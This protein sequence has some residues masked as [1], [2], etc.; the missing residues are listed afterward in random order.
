MKCAYRFSGCV[1]FDGVRIAVSSHDVSTSLSLDYFERSGYCHCSVFRGLRRRSL[2]DCFVRSLDRQPPW[3]FSSEDTILSQL[4]SVS[5][6]ILSQTA[7]RLA[8]VGVGRSTKKKFICAVC[9]HYLR[10]R[11]TLLAKSSDE[12]ASEFSSVR[13]P[14]QCDPRYLLLL[15]AFMENVYGTEIAAALRRPPTPVY[16]YESSS[17]C[18]V[19]WIGHSTDELVRRLRT[20]RLAALSESILRSPLLSR[21]VLHRRSHAH[22][23]NSLVS[24]M[25]DRVAC[26]QNVGADVLCDI[27]LAYSPYST[28]RFSQT[29]E[30]ITR[31][32]TFEYGS[33]VV[34]AL[35]HEPLS[36]S[37]R[38]RQ[39][40]RE[41]KMSALT[42]V[43]TDAVDRLN[44][45]PEIVPSST[46][47]ACQAAY[48]EGTIW[49]ADPVCAV[50]AQ[51]MEDCQK[52]DVTEVNSSELH[53]E[54]LR[55]TDAYIIRKCILQGLSSRFTFGSPIL[56]GLMLEKVGV[57]AVAQDSATLN[58]CGSC[59]AALRK[60]DRVPRLALKN[61]LY[62][63]DLPVQFQDLTWI[64]EKICAIYCVT[65][66]VTRLFQ[67][68]DPAQA[69]TFH[70]NTCAHEMNVVSTVT[71]L[72]R[73]P[74]D[75]NGLLS[76]VFVGP[77]K[78]DPNALGTV[79]RV[80]R[81]KIWTFL[82]WLKHHNRLYSA[83]PLDLAV[84]SMYPEDGILPG[85]SSG[86]IEDNDIDVQKVFDKET[87]GFSEHPADMLG[88]V[89][90]S[91]GS[92]DRDIVRP[93]HEPVVLLEKMG[94]SD[95]ECDKISGRACTA[96]ALR[97]LHSRTGQQPDLF[98]HRGM[99]AIPEYKNPDLLPG[100]FPMLFPCGIGGFEDKLR[101][102][103]LSFEQQAQYYLNLPDRAFR[104]H[105]SYL[106]VVLNI[107]QRRA[108]HLHT[109]FTVRKSNFH[110]VARKLTQVSSTVLETLATKLEREHRSST[111]TVEEQ[112][113]M[114]LLQQVNTI[115]ARIPGS[116]ASKIY[117]RNEI[118]SYFSYF[119]LPHL[120]FTFNP[121]PAHSPVFQVMFGD[122]TVD[123]S[124]R[125]P[126]LVNGRE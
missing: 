55:L 108:A 22:T 112:G 86:V 61:K 23:A 44:R 105:H 42:A 101:E 6:S 110:D 58:V 115:S 125:L 78:F 53:L 31:I 2:G 94:V 66:H 118:R 15:C 5:V 116:H 74:A 113:A 121:S 21:P 104:Y 97:N 85:L 73:T 41:H 40:R 4:D 25:R 122:D 83:I 117:V 79:F 123:L 102:A 77:G 47:L 106:F 30:L 38:L 11:S 84:S 34:D 16:V 54:S 20:V 28:A 62:R 37:D 7:T 120:F 109:F 50:C 18:V 1:T 81:R 82:V 98:V 80:R 19:A 124:H 69:K 33:T 88:D 49:K 107:L 35:S 17:D 91:V 43:A 63:G 29:S 51:H 99:D 46:V 26:L 3:L 60:P 36:R 48:F 10:L 8:C 13:L 14:P 90:S 65:A 57:V 24:H 75:V 95:P 93:S 126:T 27:W 92:Q 100:M 9:Q 96:A 114:S 111:L 89:S 52:F 59:H 76:V 56:D 64:E 67:S 70:G 103:A 68:A 71:V 87:A 32:L 39:A 45:W 119:G 12:A 72:P